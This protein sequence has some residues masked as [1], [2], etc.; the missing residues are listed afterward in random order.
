MEPARSG[1]SPSPVGL[2]S[3]DA[4]DVA[5]A[6]IG[7]VLDVAGSVLLAV[8]AVQ[9]MLD[10]PAL[11]TPARELLAGVVLEDDQL[12]DGLL[13]PDELP[14]RL[15]NLLDNLA[16]A[17]GAEVVIDDTLELSVHR[18][19][20]PSTGSASGCGRRTPWVVRT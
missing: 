16:H 13:E 12:D 5:A 11:G 15:R 10:E 4:G 17:P 9:D 18:H 1:C 6:A 8:P 19:V 20:G 7:A 2:E 3:T 14:G